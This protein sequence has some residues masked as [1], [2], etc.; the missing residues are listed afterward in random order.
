MI[1]TL[2]LKLLNLNNF[3]TLAIYVL[4][5]IC[6]EA[7]KKIKIKNGKENLLHQRLDLDF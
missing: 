6:G 2:K 7:V 4:W 1:V 3:T 5:D